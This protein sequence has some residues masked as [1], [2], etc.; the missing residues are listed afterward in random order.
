MNLSNRSLNLFISYSASI[1]LIFILLASCKKKTAAVEDKVTD[2]T[3]VVSSSEVT[4]GSN[5]PTAG[6]DGTIVTDDYENPASLWPQGIIAYNGPVNDA[7]RKGLEN[8]SPLTS[9]LDWAARC[10]RLKDSLEMI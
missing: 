7:M 3:A 4:G 9:M 10:V 8:F 1:V 2:T 5:E 6:E